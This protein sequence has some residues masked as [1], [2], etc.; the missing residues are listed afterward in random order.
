MKPTYNELSDALRNL[1]NCIECDNTEE[2]E[3]ERTWYCTGGI[4]N[5]VNRASELLTQVK[6]L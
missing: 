1:V 3:D 4:N 5:A 6:K 2:P